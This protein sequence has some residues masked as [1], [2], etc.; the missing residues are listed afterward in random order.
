MTEDLFPPEL[1]AAFRPE[2]VAPA[3]LVPGLR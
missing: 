1:L 2:L 3:A